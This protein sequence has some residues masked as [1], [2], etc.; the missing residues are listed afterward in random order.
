V[1]ALISCFH[2]AQRSGEW[3][4]WLLA[5]IP[6]KESTHRAFSKRRGDA[7]AAITLEP[8]PA[9]G[10]WAELLTRYGNEAHALTAAGDWTSPGEILR[11]LLHLHCNRRL[12]ADFRAEAEV[13]AMARGAVKAHVDR[14]RLAR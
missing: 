11:A 3:P 1:V 6:K 2:G 14:V 12:G 7:L 13:Y 10:D 5:E 9:D 8:V 4:S